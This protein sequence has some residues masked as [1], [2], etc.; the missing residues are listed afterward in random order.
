VNNNK[1]ECIA[2]MQNPQL[3]ER[4]LPDWLRECRLHLTPLTSRTVNVLFDTGALQGNFVSRELGDWVRTHA[5][6]QKKGN[7]GIWVKRSQKGL[8]GT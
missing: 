2:L 6:K 1:G 7:P 4:V 3:R 5:P 8:L